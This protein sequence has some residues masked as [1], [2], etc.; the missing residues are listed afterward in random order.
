MFSANR[1]SHYNTRWWWLLLIWSYV[2]K[3]N[4]IIKIVPT[5]NK[6]L[7]SYAWNISSFGAINASTIIVWKLISERSHERAVVAKES[8]K[9][10]SSANSMPS[11]P[12]VKFSVFEKCALFMHFI[13]GPD[14]LRINVLKVNGDMNPVCMLPRIFEN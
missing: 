6:I 12:R 1:T 4:Y 14:V 13:Q 9:T 5:L 3:T 10:V 11:V 7:L 8:Y 2:I